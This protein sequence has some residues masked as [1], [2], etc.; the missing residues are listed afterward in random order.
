[1]QQNWAHIGK[2]VNECTGCIHVYV[3]MVLQKF[4]TK[5]KEKMKVTLDKCLMKTFRNGN[6]QNYSIVN[7]NVMGH[8]CAQCFLIME[9]R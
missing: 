3:V 8:N 6:K 2:N 4:K 1:M 5:K 9:N 7:I